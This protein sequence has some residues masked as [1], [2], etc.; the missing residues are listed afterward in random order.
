MLENLWNYEARLQVK[1]SHTFGKFAEL[2]Q[3]F[4][5]KRDPSGKE[6]VKFS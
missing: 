4:A 3:N 6:Q 5:E 1:A 2:K